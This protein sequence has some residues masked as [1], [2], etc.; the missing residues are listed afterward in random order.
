[1]GRPS[2]VTVHPLTDVSMGVSSGAM[3]SDFN[4]RIRQRPVDLDG[5]VT[6]SGRAKLF[7]LGKNRAKLFIFF[8]TA[9]K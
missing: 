9:V 5:G 4:G 3:T 1:M 2:I 8:S 6:F 7:F